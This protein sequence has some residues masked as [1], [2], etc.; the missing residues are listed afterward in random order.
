[1]VATI[2]SGKQVDKLVKGGIGII[3]HFTNQAIGGKLMS[4]GFLPGTQ[5]KLISKAPFGGGCYLKAEN[6]TVALR[7][8]EANT[9][10]LR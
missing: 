9:I 5:I 4:M 3:S 7:R 2:N 10:V 1:M 8:N 6:I